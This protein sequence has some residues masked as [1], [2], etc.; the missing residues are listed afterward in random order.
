MRSETTIRSVCF[1]AVLLQYKRSRAV[2]YN[3][4][5]KQ[6]RRRP[7]TVVLLCFLSFYRTLASAFTDAT[8]IT[9]TVARLRSTQRASTMDAIYVEHKTAVRAICVTTAWPIY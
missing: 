5:S 6:S 7:S 3:S 9:I 1:I 8:I 4:L 2:K